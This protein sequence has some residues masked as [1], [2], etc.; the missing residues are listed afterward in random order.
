MA[1]SSST[2][3]ASSG[4]GYE[5]QMG[6]WSRQLAGQF[7]DFA[8]LDD[9]GLILDA[10]CGTGALSVELVRR[11]ETAEITGVDISPEYVAYAGAQIAEVRVSFETGDLTAL[12]FADATFDQGL[13]MLVLHFVPDTAGAVGKLVRVAKPGARVSA[14][15]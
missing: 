3:T 1:Q 5:L 14:T 11:T 15:V 9:G 6:R 13:S 7:I 10:G 4:N 12:G 2:F 8:G